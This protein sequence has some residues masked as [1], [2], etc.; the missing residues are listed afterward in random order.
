M[1]K[2]ISAIAAVAVS[3]A[4]NSAPLYELSND[5]GYRNN[6]WS[7]GEIFT[8][9][10]QDLTVTALGAY[11]HGL[12][13]FVSQDGIEVGLFLESDGSLL[14]STLVS[15]NDTLEGFFRFSDIADITLSAG[16]Q[17]RV[18]AAND[19]DL[20]NIAVNSSTF[21]SAVTYNGYGYCQGFLQFCND[22]QGNEIAWMANLQFEVNSNNVSEPA[23]LALLG[24]GLAG[25]GFSR[26]KRS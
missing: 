10:S 24:L 16:E 23:S 22:Y 2:L 3:G 25:V 12:D 4:V 6:S 19:E 13:G 1:K 26:R 5:Q 17:Y 21:S 15:S 14:T 20:Y 18:V 8:V 11:D 9:G 7:F